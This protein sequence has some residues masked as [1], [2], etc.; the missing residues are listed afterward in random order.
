[1]T[2]TAVAE[3]GDKRAALRTEQLS[4]GSV[5]GSGLTL[6]H[7]LARG[8]ALTRM[9]ALVMGLGNIARRQ[10]TKGA[11]FLAAEIAF[12]ALL[13]TRGIPSL[14][15][16]HV[17]GPV[18]EGGQKWDA[19]G[20]FI[21]VNPTNSVGVLLY[22]VAWV[23]IIAAFLLVW[24]AAVRSAYA[25]QLLTR[26]K[27]R[28]PSIGR[29]HPVTI[30]LRDVI[31]TFAEMGFQVWDSPEVETDERIVGHCLEQPAEHFL[32]RPAVAGP[33]QPR[34]PAPV[35]NRQRQPLVPLSGGA[36]PVDG[37]K[38]GEWAHIWRVARRGALHKGPPGPKCD[39]C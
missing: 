4:L 9:S 32:A 24:A 36:R 39:P 33:D 28:A 3:R 1:M 6:G 26:T 38:M 23:F 21:N 10:Y 25:A 11:I 14:A 18:T 37:G 13:V 15:A 12:V 8:D 7:A 31:D 17:L 20:N 19:N 30:V 2:Q 27:G 22:G 5:D 16:L 29:L 35:T 34:R